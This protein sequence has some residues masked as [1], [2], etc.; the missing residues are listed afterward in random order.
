MYFDGGWVPFGIGLRCLRPLHDVDGRSQAPRAHTSPAVMLPLDGFPR[1][2]PRHEAR[3]ASGDR[4][5]PDRQLRR[6]A[7]PC[8]STTSST[9]RSSTR[10][11]SSSRSRASTR[12]T[13]ARPS[14]STSRRL[15]TASSGSSRLSGTWRLRTCPSSSRQPRFGARRR[16]RRTTYYLGRETL[17]P[18][19]TT[20]GMWL[21]RKRLFALVVAQCEERDGLLRHSAEPRRR[22]RDE[23]DSDAPDPPSRDRHRAR[24]SR[25]RATSGGLNRYEQ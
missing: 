18:S 17:L 9:T 5:L 19:K 23:V 14:V 1:G 20:A 10:T 13:S 16:S 2:R 8:S 12:R 15:R 7:D 21:W 25:G 3:R 24:R 6:R 22:A 11:S 4:G